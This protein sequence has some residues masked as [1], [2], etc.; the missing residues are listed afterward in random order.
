MEHLFVINEVKEE[1]K[2]SL[3]VT[4]AGSQVYQTLRNLVALKKPNELEY[5]KVIECLTKHYAPPVSEIYERYVFNTCVQKPDQSVA[6]YM[7]ELRKLASTCN[8]GTFLD[9]ALRDRFVCGIRSENIQKKL[10]GEAELKF[11][12]ACK[13]ALAVEVAEKQVRTLA[14][15]SNSGVHQITRAAK[16]KV[17]KE[18]RMDVRYECGGRLAV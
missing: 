11:S 15:G 2:V 10:L 7:I 3:F 1:T 17:T 5:K 4:L 16:G 12:D 18:T 14:E 13:L 9:D 8:F 6:K